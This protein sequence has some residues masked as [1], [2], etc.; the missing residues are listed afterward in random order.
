MAV[1]QQPQCDNQLL[2]TTKRTTTTALVENN[3][4]N[5]TP[6]ATTPYSTIN[7]PVGTFVAGCNVNESPFETLMDGETTTNEDKWIDAGW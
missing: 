5:L 6:N 7:S 1:S 3:D 2:A 4:N